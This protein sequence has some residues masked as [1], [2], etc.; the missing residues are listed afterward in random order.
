MLVGL[1]GRFGKGTR[2]MKK[3]I[4]SSILVLSFIIC[5]SAQQTVDPQK[6]APA[7]SVQAVD[8]STLNKK[9]SI[10]QPKTSTTGTN[11]SKIKDL[12]R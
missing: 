7:K 12:F 5:A 1:S 2:K 10:V 11:W 9:T 4:V 8:K 6:I 3:V